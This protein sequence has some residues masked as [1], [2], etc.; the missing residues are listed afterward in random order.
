MAQSSSML[1]IHYNIRDNEV[2]NK[3]ESHILQRWKVPN[4]TEFDFISILISGDAGTGKSCLQDGLRYKTKLRPYYV[5]A[6][7]S[8]GGVIKKIFIDNQYYTHD[9]KVYETTFKQYKLTPAKWAIHVAN[10]YGGIGD[11]SQ[12]IPNGTVDSPEKFWNG[13]SK[14][15]KKVCHNIIEEYLNCPG[16]KKAF[17]SP[18]DYHRYKHYVR[19]SL[20]DVENYSV[21]EIHDLTMNH[22]KFCIPACQIP[23]QLFYHTEVV[24]EVGR[25]EVTWMIISIGL[26]YYIHTKYNTGLKKPVYVG[27]GSCTQSSVFNSTCFHGC[28]SEGS[29]MCA[30]PKIPINE[31]S[32]LTALTSNCIHFPPE[33]FAKENKHNRRTISGDPDKYATLAIMRNNLEM[34][35]P[36][37]LNIWKYIEKHMCVSEEDFYNSSGLIHLCVTH[38]EGQKV[39]QRDKVEPSDVIS[40][41]DYMYSRGV[42]WPPCLYY[43]TYVMNAVFKSA[44]YYNNKWERRDIRN[45]HKEMS[46]GVRKYFDLLTPE[47]QMGLY[48]QLKQSIPPDMPYSV[49]TATRAFHKRRPYITTNAVNC[50][51]S[52][53]SGTLYD[54]LDDISQYA[55]IFNDNIDIFLIFIRLI[56]E[57]IEFRF[58][59]KVELCQ[60]ILV[61]T[62]A[63]SNIEDL[64]TCITELTCLLIN[65]IT[66]EHSEKN[67]NEVLD[68]ETD[69][70][71]EDLDEEIDVDFSTGLLS[72]KCVTKEDNGKED[73]GTRD[74]ISHCFRSIKIGYSCDPKDPKIYISIPKTETLILEDSS[75]NTSMPSLKLRLGKTIE[76][77]MYRAVVKVN[78]GP[79]KYQ[80]TEFVNNKYKRKTD[81]LS[82][83]VTK[84]LKNDTM[85]YTS[86]DL[87]EEEL[88][89]LKRNSLYGTEES[90]VSN[91]IQQEIG[92]ED[93]DPPKDFTV[94]DFF[95]I[96]KNLNCTV[97]SAQGLTMKGGVL[98][99]ITKQ[100]TAN[101]LIVMTTRSSSA[102][103]LKFFMKDIPGV[104]PLDK[105]TLSTIKTMHIRSH[106]TGT[107]YL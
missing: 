70:E 93:S 48:G 4:V 65:A 23:D 85:E 63:N 68:L 3:I 81:L 31:L 22:I 46:F 17:I 103:N 5:G 12:D 80:K 79:D 92:Q 19:A 7:N 8:A 10:L 102:D 6:T 49:W 100:M 41:P 71:D 37:A 91:T 51:L 101:D 75:S 53:I 73:L 9:F 16:N 106:Q 59:N 89:G 33:V 86:S 60:K 107:G 34:N 62:S 57:N 69:E 11:I 26:W 35:E 94:L 36:I 76:V 54:L 88:I 77:V 95:P 1:P 72:K 28:S 97:A 29:D 45:E 18:E 43:C 83:T 74:I 61:H 105:K 32:F 50:V 55:L 98:A 56:V 15:L 78:Q 66:Q 27:V 25:I 99:L 58:P 20:P 2:L 39:L 40:L 87:S 21:R 47:E 13:I 84:K 14:N 42:K 104:T 30:H 52:G 44:N 24:D 96:K 67:T 38:Q 90:V 64:K 82:E